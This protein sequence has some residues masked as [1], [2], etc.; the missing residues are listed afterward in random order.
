M[1][2][3]PVNINALFCCKMKFCFLPPLQSIE[4]TSFDTI[5]PL[6]LILHCL[7]YGRYGITPIIL[8][9]DEV[10]QAYAII[11]NSIIASFTSL[12]KWMN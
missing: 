8:F 9:A 6:F 7:E 4:A 10:L 12:N 5:D 11:S 3:V 1:H 2:P